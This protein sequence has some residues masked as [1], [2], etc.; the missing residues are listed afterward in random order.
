MSKL[1]LWIPRVYAAAVFFGLWAA[2]GRED[3]LYQKVKNERLTQGFAAAAG[4][5][6]VL[7]ASLL[8]AWPLAL[9]A[10]FLYSFL[11]LAAV[12]VALCAATALLLWYLKVWPAGDVKLFVL[13]AAL[14][15]L[16]MPFSAVDYT[17]VFFAALV[18][19]FLPAQVFVFCM[20][21]HYLVKTRLVHGRRYLVELGWRRELPFLVK[22]GWTTAGETAR[23]AWAVVV[24][25]ARSPK[26]SWGLALAA[27]GHVKRF[28]I[29]MAAMALVSTWAKQ[30]VRSPLLLSLGCTLLFV[31]WGKMSARLGSWWIV[32]VAAALAA[33]KL[34]AWGPFS[35]GFD[36]GYFFSALGQISV[37]GLFMY[38][39]MSAMTRSLSGGSSVGIYVLPLVL[40]LVMMA[41]SQGLMVLS[42]AGA[43]AVR[44][45][46][47]WPVMHTLRIGHIPVPPLGGLGAMPHLPAWIMPML[48]KSGVLAGFGLFFGLSLVLVRRWDQESRPTWGRD[49]LVPRLLLAPDFV[50]KLRE[51]EEFFERHFSTMYPDGLTDSQAKALAAWCRRHEILEVPLAP[52]L[53][54]AS[55]IFL[56]FLLCGLF[57][58]RHLL[59]FVTL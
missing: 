48:H 11:P 24:S 5:Y 1:A 30:W 25:A 49:G 53:S 33:L 55:W 26:L 50:E 41:L 54:F 21:V 38:F 14:L 51:D 9:V 34:G 39:G 15:P 46:S 4:G 52:T 42:M 19:I 45:L 59:D 17:R 56:G 44:W 32:V 27:L 13:L 23:K 7:A 28:L 8:L 18:N 57:E 47:S 10:G 35:A 29:G 2:I 20:A 36:W 22:T 6:L 37:F 3:F 12:N 40:P 43:A 31:G 16:T 58:G